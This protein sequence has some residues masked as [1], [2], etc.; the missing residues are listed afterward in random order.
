MTDTIYATDTSQR[1]PASYWAI[2]VAG[3]LWNSFGAYDYLMTRTENREYLGQMGDPQALLDWI[4]SFPLWSQICWGLGVWGS[5]LGSVLMLVRSRHA[6]TA[7]A[8]SLV[9][10]VLSLGYT[11]LANPMPAG[12]ESAVGKVMPLVIIAVVAALWWYCR[13]AFAKGWLK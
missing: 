13:R 7:F 3:A 2:A 6:A 4:D 8:V 5:V 12:M 11:A 10:A 9:G 1:A